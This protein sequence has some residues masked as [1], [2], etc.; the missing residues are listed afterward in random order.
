MNITNLLNRMPL[1]LTGSADA[2]LFVPG[3]AL[4]THLGII[5]LAKMIDQG[6][7]G[8]PVVPDIMRTGKTI[9]KIGVRRVTHQVQGVAQVQLDGGPL[10]HDLFLGSQGE[11]PPAR[12]Q[13]GAPVIFGTVVPAADLRA[14]SPAEN[15]L[16]VKIPDEADMPQI[17]GLSFDDPLITI[18]ED[19][20]ENIERPPIPDL[21]RKVR[22]QPPI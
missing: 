14:P 15:E 3:A 11:H 13:Q 19:I 4:V 9:C 20:P 22:R 16:A 6:E 8:P 5:R 1:L 7:D 2:A 12:C 10:L 18:V 21:F 17:D